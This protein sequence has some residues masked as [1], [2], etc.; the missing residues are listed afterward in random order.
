M[1]HRGFFRT[2]GKGTMPRSETPYF[3]YITTP[4]LEEAD[5]IARVLVERRLCACVNILPG[6]TSVYHWEGTIHT[7]EEVVLIAKTS[8]TALKPLIEAVTTLHPYEVPAI[9]AW[10]VKL[11]NKVFLRW[12]VEETLCREPLDTP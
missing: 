4:S 8:G 5:V 11:G 7:A 12:V 10:P 2:A 1:I 6:T 3:V 9:A